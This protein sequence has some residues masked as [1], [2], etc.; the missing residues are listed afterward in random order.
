MT[1][2]TFCL[3]DVGE[4][5][6]EAEIVAWHVGVGDRIA[7]NEIVCDIETAKS[8]VELPSPYEG[9]VAELHAQLSE[10]VV[11]G[12]PLI[13]VDVPAETSPPP[14]EPENKNE[15]AS[16]LV[17]VGDG[18]KP[19]VARRLHISP[20]DERPDAVAVAAGA[21]PTVVRVPVTGVRKATAA[22]MVQSAFTAPH[23][24][25]WM[26]CDVT[27]TLELV[28]RVRRAPE[29][30]DRRVTPLVFVARA[31][32]IALRSFP[33]LNASW[34][35]D[36][37][38]IVLMSQVNL[39]IAAAT[40]RGLV[41]PNIKGAERLALPELA[42]AINDLVDTARAGKTRPEGMAHGTVTITNLGPLGVDGATPILNPGETAILAVGAARRATL[43][44]EDRVEIR[45]VM[46]LSLSIDHRV[47][48]G[49]L[50]SNALARIA[51]ILNDPHEAMWYV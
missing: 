9:I 42:D 18:P 21:P 19:T 40:P 20:P 31:L 23:A 27:A 25:I 44:V 29:W 10:T 39:G 1:R 16:P 15:D 11:V 48:D 49:A 50:A 46:T 22:A 7:V 34:H 43:P 37:Q 28:R 6:T 8:V 45:E 3:P 38:E 2:N 36:E 4:G 13:S 24:T 41:V 51:A 30:A 33:D 5:L 35:E 47:V 26:T 17:L 14:T 12:R 32:L